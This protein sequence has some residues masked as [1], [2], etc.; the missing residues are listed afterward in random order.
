MLRI[1]QELEGASLISSVFGQFRWFDLAFLIPALVLMGLTYTD[2]GRYTPLVRAAGTALFG[3]FWFT[4]VPVYLSPG[5]QDIIN[6]LM[7]FLGGIF[8]LFIAYHFLLDHL[9]EERTRSLEWLLRTSVLTGG[10]Y[11]V[12][13]H[14]PVTQGA[15]IYMV[16]W[17]TYL[18]LRLFGHDVM[19]ENHFPGSVGDGIVISSGD[20]SVDLPIRIVF[21]C[22]AALALFLFASAVM[23]TRTDRNEWKGWALR[24]LSRLKG[25]RNL[26]H[27]MKR[28][29]IKNILRMTDGQR[30]LYAILA[31][32]PLI[33]VTNIFRNV[34]VIA[35]TFSGMIPFYDAHNIYAKML[36]LG[37][38]VFLTWMLFELLPELQEDVMGLFDLTKRVRKGMIKNGRMDLKYIRNTGEKR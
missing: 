20:P 16:A 24:E 8:F 12:L 29:G 23:A 4:Q 17:L 38:M 19:I 7:S 36:S 26:L 2:R 22:T 34:G 27:R 6:G 13:E 32:I 10:A 15:L 21:A 9:W 1:M 5:H 28:N 33:F 14:V 37:M 3:M 31:V 11:F 25:S 18:T 30:K 35:V